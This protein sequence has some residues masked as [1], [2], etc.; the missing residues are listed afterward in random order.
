MTDIKIEKIYNPNTNKYLYLSKNKELI[1]KKIG[2]F[3]EHEMNGKSKTVRFR[4]L[5]FSRF[6]V[7]RIADVVQP[8]P[9]IKL[10]KDF[11]DNP[12]FFKMPSN[13]K[14]TLDIKPISSNTDIKNIKSTI[15]GIN[16]TTLWIATKTPS[17][18]NIFI[19]YDIFV[20]KII[21]RKLSIILLKI[22]FIIEEIS[23]PI[24]P[25]VI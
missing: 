10:N 20:H 24:G 6:L 7:V 15:C 9:I 16:E 25:N 14:A 21:F 1:T 4:K 5:T 11:P 22:L 18:I 19:I 23:V 17:I 3:A 2:S 8:Y 13:I 12:T